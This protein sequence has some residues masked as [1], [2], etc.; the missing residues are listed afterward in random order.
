M[1]TGSKT[2]LDC[3]DG[4]LDLS[5]VAIGGDNVKNNWSECLSDTLKFVV[6]MDV[7]HGESS[8]TVQFDDAAHLRENGF[9]R[10]IGDWCN[11]SETDSSGD[12]VQKN[13][14]LDKEK[15]N[16]EG[17]ISL[18]LEYGRWY[19]N[20]VESGCSGCGAGSGHLAL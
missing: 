6:S 8:S 11:R 13:H 19:E 3:P 16:A 7:S 10:P 1:R 14:A 2:L 4:A 18:V 15:I 9:A 12:G 5:H 20:R 17:N